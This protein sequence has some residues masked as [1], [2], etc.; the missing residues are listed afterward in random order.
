MCGSLFFFS[1]SEER[2]RSRSSFL[3]RLLFSLLFLAERL[4]GLSS[5]LSPRGEGWMS[6]VH[7]FFSDAPV[8]PSQ[9]F[10]LSFF[11]WSGLRAHQFCEVVFFFPFITPVLFLLLPG[12]SCAAGAY[13]LFFFSPVEVG[14]GMRATPFFFRSYLFFSLLTFL[15][16]TRKGRLRGIPGPS[17]FFFPP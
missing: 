15:P 9:W 5:P 14:P 2:R 3:K 4:G 10:F 7:Y 12:G 11:L 16:P 13:S 17:P 8:S 6:H 1:G